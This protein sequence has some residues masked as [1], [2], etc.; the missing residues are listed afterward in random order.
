M[1]EEEGELLSVCKMSKK[2]KRKTIE[3]KREE[4]GGWHRKPEGGT[5]S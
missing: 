5:L 1:W 3:S 2:S 4:G